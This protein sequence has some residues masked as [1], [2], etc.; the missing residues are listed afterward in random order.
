MLGRTA[1]EAADHG[2]VR[3]ADAHRHEVRQIQPHDR[4]QPRQ[5]R[6]DLANKRRQSTVRVMKGLGQI[7]SP[8]NVFAA[9]L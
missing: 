4:Q 1:V 9:K 7:V 3:D 8:G 5:Q 6:R 2:H